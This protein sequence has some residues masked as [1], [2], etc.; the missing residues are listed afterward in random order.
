M[1]VSATY[2]ENVYLF[3]RLI[4]GDYVIMHLAIIIYTPV[5]L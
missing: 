3:V 2:L 4:R 5:I 1:M